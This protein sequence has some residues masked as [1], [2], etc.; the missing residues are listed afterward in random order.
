MDS[1]IG[2]ADRVDVGDQVTLAYYQPLRAKNDMDNHGPDTL[3]IT[4]GRNQLPSV[5]EQELLGMQLYEE[6]SITLPA[7]FAYGPHYPQLVGLLP[8]TILP[9]NIDPQQG[10]S[11]SF[12]DQNG[13][14]LEARVI[15]VREDSVVMDM[16]HP[17]AGK[18]VDLLA[19][20]VRIDSN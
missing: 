4:I 13:T 18:D 14:E 12:Q 10:M 7:R 16:N 17:L 8:K 2:N 5:I 15:E 3:V 19:T 6:K 11:V 20:V 1:R 9:Q